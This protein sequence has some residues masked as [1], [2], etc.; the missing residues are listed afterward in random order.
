MLEQFITQ[1]ASANAWVIFFSIIL[2]S[3]ISEDIAVFGAAFAAASNSLPLPFAIT[4]T[5]TGIMSGSLAL[6][7][8]GN[9]A[10]NWPFIKRKI[11]NNALL[12]KAEQILLNNSFINI[13]VVRFAPGIRTFI[14]VLCGYYKVSLIIFS[15]AVLLASS[16]WTAIIFY[17]FYTFGSAEWLHSTQN[18]V[19]VLCVCLIILF[20]INISSK[21]WLLKKSS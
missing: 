8:I 6:Y 18:K 13:F 1:S 10:H 21:K 9:A 4:A 11:D 3:Y 5:L 15:T 16:I 12:H 14:F 20:L 7:Y 19:I 17:S 2:I